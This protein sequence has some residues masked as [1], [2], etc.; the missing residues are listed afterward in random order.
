MQYTALIIVQT[1]CKELLER[2]FD[3][4]VRGMAYPNSGILHIEGYTSYE[5]I[6]SYLSDV[7]ILYGESKTFQCGT[8][9]ELAA[10]D[11]V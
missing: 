2:R 5:K 6:C 10:D 4:I 8:S 9:G 7:G 3:I 1:D 11:R